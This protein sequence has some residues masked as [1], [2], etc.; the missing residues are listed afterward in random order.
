MYWTCAEKFAS[1]RGRTANVGAEGHQSPPRS[2]PASD[3][4]GLAGRKRRIGSFE[5]RRRPETL[6]DFARLVQEGRGVGC[7]P[8]TKKPLP[9][10]ELDDGQVEG[11]LMVRHGVGC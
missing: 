10:L 7:P 5:P 1:S 3:P 9:V 11:Q 8:L 2:E 4:L 6:E